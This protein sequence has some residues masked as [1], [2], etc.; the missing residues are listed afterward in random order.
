MIRP[1]TPADT[2]TLLAL[3]DAT[4]VFKSHEITALDE[5][6]ADYHSANRDLGH[7]CVTSEAGGQIT[8]FAYHAPAAMTDRT[9]YLYWIAVDKTRH[10][11]G[12]GGELLRY[13]EGDVRDQGGRILLIETSSLP[14]Y[15]LTRRF[16][17]KHGY[18]K[19]AVLPDYYSD[20]DDMVVFRKRLAPTVK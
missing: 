10:A 14:H 7:R 13:V 18:D 16:Y 19:V 5:V 4:G 12:L 2:P 8:G 6:L 9:W 3:A 20:G 15:E 11:R 1:T 17:V